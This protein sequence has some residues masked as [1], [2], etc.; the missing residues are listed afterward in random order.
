GTALMRRSAVE[1]VD[2]FDSDLMAG[3]EPDF[4]VRL[5]RQG[6]LVL[7]L[8][9]PMLF[10]DL[11][12]TR[13]SQY[14]RRLA[15]KG[16]GDVEVSLRY[17]RAEMPDFTWF[18]WRSRLVA[19]VVVLAPVLSAVLCLVTGSVIPVAVV[20]AGLS[21]AVVNAAWSCRRRASDW[22]QSAL[23]GAH[24]L[25]RGKSRFCLDSSGTCSTAVRARSVLLNTSLRYP[26]RPR[27]RAPAI[28]RSLRGR[29]GPARP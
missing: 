3:E 28:D 12:M 13:F 20:I 14:W 10:H 24:V 27:P 16:Y 17:P 15:R 29:Q 1:S 6:F 18:T 9:I 8:D 5:R 19:P 26:P 22:R 2:G 11:S 21:I 7:G 25:I 23:F 4:C